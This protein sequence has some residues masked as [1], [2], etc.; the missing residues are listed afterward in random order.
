ME[1]PVPTL[2]GAINRARQA[3]E[4]HQCRYKLQ[5]R[6]RR[7]LEKAAAEYWT[8]ARVRASAAEA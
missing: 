1:T 8:D 2:E 3:I 6:S 4:G 7:Q 5:A